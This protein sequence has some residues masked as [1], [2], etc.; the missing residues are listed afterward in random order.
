MYIYIQRHKYIHA[1]M[2]GRYTY[3]KVIQIQRCSEMGDSAKAMFD[4]GIPCC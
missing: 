1:H 3:I 2:Y 4:T